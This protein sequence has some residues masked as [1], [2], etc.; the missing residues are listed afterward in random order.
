MDDAPGTA[1]FEV[2]RAALF[3]ARKHRSGKRKDADESPYINHPLAVAAV[4]AEHGV[5]DPVTL[6]AALLHDT[7]EDTETTPA[8]LEREFGFAVARVVL[9]V[10]DDKAL[11]KRERKRLQIEKSAGLSERA[12]LVK[13]G[14]KICNAH[15]VAWSPPKDWPPSRR[16][17]YL[18]WTERVVQGCRGT[19]PALEE[20]YDRVLAEAR[21]SLGIGG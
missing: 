9:E 6:Q 7:L 19:N 3:A 18:D 20:R 12:K 16:V 21:G 13:L 14:D 1:P 8:E 11:E 10:T 5:E 15:D 2:L 4:L 17:E